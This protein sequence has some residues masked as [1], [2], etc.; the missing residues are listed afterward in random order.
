MTRKSKRE[1]EN[2]LEEIESDEEELG[3]PFDEAELE[4]LADSSIDVEAWSQTAQRR[5]VLRALMNAGRED[6]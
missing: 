1:I 4:R 6:R 3:R 5:A 2:A